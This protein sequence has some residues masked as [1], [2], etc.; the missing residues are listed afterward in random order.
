MFE[1]NKDYIQVGIGPRSQSPPLFQENSASSP[2]KMEEHE[3]IVK[4][5][6]NV[7]PK[8]VIE[9]NT[10]PIEPDNGGKDANVVV[11]PKAPITPDETTENPSNKFIYIVIIIIVV[12]II[13]LVLI[14]RCQTRKS[15]YF[16][17][18]SD[19]QAPRRLDSKGYSIN[20]SIASAEDL[21]DHLDKQNQD[22]L[23]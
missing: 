20:T 17:T 1:Q 7:V 18:V 10:K 14:Y 15:R 11:V 21:V 19:Q 5:E 23:K 13:V 9:N 6:P 22:H 8:P 3:N 12:L 16:L 4:D 2:F